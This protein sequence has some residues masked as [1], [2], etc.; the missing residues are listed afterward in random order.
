MFQFVIFISKS[1]LFGLDVASIF[2]H[3]VIGSIM[4]LTWALQV[5]KTAD[6]GGLASRV[7]TKTSQANLN[8]PMF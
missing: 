1:S 4:Q 3:F 2:N 8:N 5:H 6:E 7:Y